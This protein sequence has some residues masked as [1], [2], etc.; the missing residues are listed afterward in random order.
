MAPAARSRYV[1]CMINDT[2]F[3]QTA[4]LMREIAETLI[5]PRFRSL[6][7]A[8]ITEKSG[9]GD[10]VTIADQEA[11]LALTPRLM[12]LLPGSVVVGEEAVS[13]DGSVLERLSE[14]AP[15][16]LVDPVDGTANFVR[17]ESNFA[18]MVALVVKGETRG[19][20]IFAPVENRMA[21]AAPGAGAFLEG[22]RLQTNRSV[23]FQDAYG[24]Y[25]SKYMAEPYRSLLN[26]CLRTV[27][28]ARQGHCSAYAYLDTARG[29]LDFVLQY[30]MNPWDH[31][32]GELLVSEAGGAS[33]FLDDATVY[34][35]IVQ[36]HRPMLTI[37]DAA[38]WTTFAER[39]KP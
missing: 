34:R 13:A 26:D 15:V 1:L 8:D 29:E 32:A 20:W 10:L 2:L 36:P 14:D 7:D 27:R 17:G 24:D 16:W 35:P 19:A 23:K 25:S 4:D 12:D 18:V 3:D 9:P 22:R 21:M 28:G 30:M 33:R 37:G 5:L 11:E 31:A 39:L 6:N 38:Q